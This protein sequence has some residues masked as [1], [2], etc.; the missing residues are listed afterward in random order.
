MS[1]NADGMESLD[2]LHLALLLPTR[3]II[4]LAD[5]ISDVFRMLWPNGGTGDRQKALDY[6][7]I[8]CAVV[9]KQLT[10]AS[11]S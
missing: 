2:S 11:P 3:L 5:R 10:M 9:P 6:V 1:Q 8:P 7:N 4:R